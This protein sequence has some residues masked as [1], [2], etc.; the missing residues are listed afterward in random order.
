MAKADPWRTSM[1]AVRNGLATF[2]VPFLFFYSP[3]LLGKG[4]WYEVSAALASAIVGV[5]FLACST[6]GWLNGP[7]A[8]IERALLF[9]GAIGLMIPEL[10]SSIVGL[11]LGVG[12]YA[13][14]R[15]RHGANPADKV[16]APTL[17]AA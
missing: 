16:P 4:A 12:V 17:S 1:I 6:E 15:W 13:Y 10:Y 7:L 11:A 9:L 5:Y 8:W 2:I 3:V 14:Q